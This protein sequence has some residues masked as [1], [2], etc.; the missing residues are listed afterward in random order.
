MERLSVYG[1]ASNDAA[2]GASAAGASAATATLAAAD[3]SSAHDDDHASYR[4]T[5]LTGDVFSVSKKVARHIGYVRDCLD[6]A[7]GDNSVSIYNTISPQHMALVRKC[8]QHALRNTCTVL[9]HACTETQQVIEFC[10]RNLTDPIK[11]IARVCM[12]ISGQCTG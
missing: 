7:E 5:L 3:A 9:T 1:A 8:S 11:V 4:L 12:C 2:A 6:S 10:E